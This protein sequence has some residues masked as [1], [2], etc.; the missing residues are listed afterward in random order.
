MIEI[1]SLKDI[2]LLEILNTFNASFSD[3]LIPM[4]LSENEFK[5]KLYTEYINWDFSV[6][7]FFDQNLVAFIL[8]FDDFDKGK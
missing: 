2:S 7:V 8:L 1:K 3:Y 4:N 6:G 5:T